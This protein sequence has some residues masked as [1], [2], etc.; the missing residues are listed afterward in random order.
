MPIGYL[1]T[2][3]AH[4]FASIGRVLSSPVFA[5]ALAFV[6][7]GDAWS[8]RMQAKRGLYRSAFAEL[9]GPVATPGGMPLVQSYYLVEGGR[10]VRVMSDRAWYVIT[11]VDPTRSPV[12]VSTLSVHVTGLERWGPYRPVGGSR[13]MWVLEEPTVDDGSGMNLDKRLLR[14][15]VHDHLRE[16]ATQGGG[17]RRETVEKLSIDDFGPSPNG[18]YSAMVRQIDFDLVDIAHNGAVAFGWLTLSISAIA[19]P[20]GTARRRRRRRGERRIARG[21]CVRCGY[22]L[23]AHDAPACPEC[24]TPAKS[25][26]GSPGTTA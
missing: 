21:Q 13:E 26:A 3:S 8:V 17:V 19:A 24:G 5:V 2:I 11:E 6:L 12:I 16:R 4:V 20:I 23:S 14:E 18:G 7:V 22:D 9:I 15:F 10:G 25:P 1:R